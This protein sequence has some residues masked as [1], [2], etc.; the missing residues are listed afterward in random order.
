M[1][2]QKI[3]ANI[4]IAVLIVACI[5]VGAMIINNL[6]GSNKTTDIIDK[7]QVG[8]TDVKVDIEE[9]KDKQT[10]TGEDSTEVKSKEE[11]QVEEEIKKVDDEVKEDGAIPKQESEEVVQRQTEETTHE[12]PIVEQEPSQT[13]KSEDKP[14]QSNDQQK[15]PVIEEPKVE[16][17]PT[18]TNDDGSNLVPDSEN[19]FKQPID[20]MSNN[21]TRGEMNGS[22]YYQDGVSAGQGDKF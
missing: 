22:D 18:T 15:E 10:T 6:R 16:P 14:K 21:G 20:I 2:N 7:T 3:K 11:P 9:P 1:R 12:E 13:E 17:Q 4:V 19:P 5:T 8:Q